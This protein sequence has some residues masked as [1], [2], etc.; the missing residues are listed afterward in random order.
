MTDSINYVAIAVSLG[1][2][3]LLTVGL[4][5]ILRLMKVSYAPAWAIGGMSIFGVILTGMG[6]GVSEVLLL[7]VVVPLVGWAIYLIAK[8]ASARQV[9]VGC[10]VCACVVGLL[11]LLNAGYEK[12]IL[13]EQR[14]LQSAR[15]G[16]ALM[17]EQAAIVRNLREDYDRQRREFFDSRASQSPAGADPES[18]RSFDDQLQTLRSSSGVAWYPEVDERFDADV[19]PSM[20][21]SGRSLGRKLIRLMESVTKDENDPPIIRIHA[22]QV[23]RTFSGIRKAEDCTDALNELAAVMRGRYP[24]AQV[25][26]DQVSST[27]SVEKLDPNAVSIE[28]KTSAVQSKTAPWNRSKNEL[29]ADVIA[30]LSGSFGK[31]S[32]SVRLVDKPWV[33]NFDQFLAENRSGSLEVDA[34]SG[35]LATSAMEARKLAIEDG[36]NMLTSV[37]MGLLSAQPQLLLRMPREAEIADRLRSELLGS[38]DLV[39][40]SFSQRLAHPLGDLWREAILIRADSRAMQ[41]LINDFITQ[42]QDEQSGRLS[43]GAA[44]ALLAIGIIV[45]HALLNWITKGYHRKSVGMLSALFAVVSVLVVLIVALKFGAGHVQDV[46]LIAP[47]A[48]VTFGG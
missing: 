11:F 14:D 1:V 7:L 17:A 23:R 22:S 32:I 35:R 6:G 2:V 40:D 47:E 44:L 31:A 33:H 9:A 45:Q 34:R 15:M 13:S 48:A 46:R 4:T 25:L 8:V 5:C 3:T 39:V 26:V 24:E 43:L 12:R 36:V 37:A 21:A 18:D 16:E 19:Q 30:E 27:N 38:S 29:E 41:K 28:L 10:A 42:R 20:A